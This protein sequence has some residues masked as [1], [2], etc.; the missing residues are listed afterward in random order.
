MIRRPPRSTLFPYT[1]LF[2]SFVDPCVL[3]ATRSSPNFG[4][5]C[6]NVPVGYVQANR[7]ISSLLTSN[8]NLKP[9]TGHVFTYGLVYDPGWLG[10]FSSTVDFWR[11][12]INDTITQ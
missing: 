9:E 11:Y 10:G 12:E 4:L 5:A 3:A 2:R 8:P 6:Q 1:T 7:Q